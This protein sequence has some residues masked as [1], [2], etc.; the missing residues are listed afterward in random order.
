MKKL[1]EKL[2]ALV[3]EATQLMREERQRR[4]LKFMTSPP[5]PTVNPQPWVPFEPV[6]RHPDLGPDISWQRFD[7][8]C[9][10]PPFQG[11]T[12]TICELQP[13]ALYGS[14]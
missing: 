6:P 14:H 13:S 8:T 9:A 3:D 1:L 5:G 12:V 2:E 7:V 10:P 4:A 11:S